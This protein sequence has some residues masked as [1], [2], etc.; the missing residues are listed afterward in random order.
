MLMLSSN[1]DKLQ[2]GN[3]KFEEL[4]CVIISINNHMG[5]T[6]SL[7]QQLDVITFI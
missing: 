4:E 7:T 3:F 6:N 1:Y 2:F 5:V